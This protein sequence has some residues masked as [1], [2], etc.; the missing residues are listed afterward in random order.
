MYRD[1]PG[2]ISQINRRRAVLAVR[3][4]GRGRGNASVSANSSCS[5]LYGP[6]LRSTL[7]GTFGCVWSGKGSL[8]S[9]LERKVPVPTTTTSP[10]IFVVAVL[11]LP[12]LHPLSSSRGGYDATLGFLSSATLGLSGAA[13][14]HRGRQPQCGLIVSFCRRQGS[15]GDPLN[16]TADKEQGTRSRPIWTRQVKGGDQRHHV[17]RHGSTCTF[18]HVSTWR[19]LYATPLRAAAVS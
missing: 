1:I 2:T 19:L 7:A 17:V 12:L 14:S 5:R 6:W 8:G 4:D 15:G 11:S 9:A 16:S 13:A 3:A 10:S 18:D